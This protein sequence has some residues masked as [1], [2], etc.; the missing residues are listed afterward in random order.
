LVRPSG[1]KGAG[2]GGR[3]TARVLTFALACA[4]AS[5][6]AAQ[7]ADNPLKR[8]MKTFGFATD[9]PESQDFVRQSRPQKEP[10]YI[11]VF[12]P[13]P[14]PARPALKDKE[15][16]TLKGDLDSVQKR[17][18]AVRQGFPPAA[19]AVADEQAE[20]AKKAAAKQ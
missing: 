18:D 2:R 14:E 15:L 20:K 10:D 8:V 9:L 13:P 5:V 11:P 19:K 7:Q 17:A 6:A 16:N 4:A 3:A 12:Q 1:R